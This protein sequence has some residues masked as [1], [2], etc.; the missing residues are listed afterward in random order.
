MRDRL[1]SH[2]EHVRDCQ[3]L[4]LPVPDAMRGRFVVADRVGTPEQRRPVPGLSARGFVE[5][6]IQL[7]NWK[8]TRFFSDSQVPR[9]SRGEAP[10]RLRK[11]REK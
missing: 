1:S 11:Q 9:H 6:A 4:R 10:K 2:P 5:L 7:V 8:V 3:A